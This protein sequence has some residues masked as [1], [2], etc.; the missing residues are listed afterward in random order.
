MA[1]ALRK[2]FSLLL[3]F[4]LPSCFYGQLNTVANIDEAVLST[5]D[6]TYVS[7]GQGIGNYKTA[8]GIKKLNPL[9]FEGQISPDFLF[10]LSKKRTTGIAFF[11]KIVI[12]MY[13]EE[14][15]PVKTPSYMPSLLY[16]HRIKSPFTRKIFRFFTSEEQLAFITYRVS[17]HS[18]GQ[19]GTYYTVNTDSVNFIN[20]NF[21]TNAAEIAFSWS[22]IDS[23]SVGKAFVNGRIAYERQLNFEREISLM[24]TYYF[25]KITLESH[26]IYSQKFKAY[27]NYAFMFGTKKFGTRQSLD[28]Y[29]VYKPFH[30]LT[31]FSVFMRGYFGPDYYNLYYV[32]SL[33][34]LTLGIIADPLNI[35]VFR[36]QKRNSPKKEK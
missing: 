8:S 31:D 29:L 11:P 30:K 3:I 17:H 22:T 4:F 20:G 27:I 24:N 2:Y 32:N 12:R 15:F 10:T 9:I 16:Y 5:S 21:S 26:I 18:N 34:V 25:N 1:A 19:S 7:F 28:L 35:P 6:R 14:S 33:R 13:N 23:G 36:K